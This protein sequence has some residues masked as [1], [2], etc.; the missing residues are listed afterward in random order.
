[1]VSYNSGHSYPVGTVG[2]RLNADIVNTQRLYDSMLAMAD[3]LNPVATISAFI[4]PGGSG[5]NYAAGDVWAYCNGQTIDTNGR[6][7]LAMLATR[8]GAVAGVVTI[9]DLRGEFLR[10]LDDG[11]GVVGNT[12]ASRNVGSWEDGS[13]ASHTHADGTFVNLLKVP[14]PGSL[15]GG[16]TGQSGVEQAVGVGDG[17]P[18]LAVGG[19]ETRP[20]NVAVR[21]IM[22]VRSFAPTTLS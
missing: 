2:Q 1:M 14:Y 8:V 19:V 18:M 9:P 10:G 3:A 11:R 21:Y 22:R 17:G 20:R 12:Q 15:T 6:A 4:G 13:F 5:F 7:D 16:D